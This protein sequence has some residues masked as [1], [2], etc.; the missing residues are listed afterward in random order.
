MTL[1]PPAPPALAPSL[2]DLLVA[3]AGAPAGAGGGLVHL[4]HLPARTARTAELA[5]P[6]PTLVRDRLGVD[7]FWSH[8]AE[9]ID[10]ARAGR[11]VAV[12]TG[13]ASGKSLCYQAPLAEAVSA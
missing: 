7:A 9:A 4:E 13:T 1:A 8:Q 5:R 12:A 2:E 3:L 6:L 11:S 10:L